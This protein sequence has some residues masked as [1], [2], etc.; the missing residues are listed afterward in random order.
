MLGKALEKPWE[1]QV[2]AWKL[3]SNFPRLGKTLGNALGNYAAP[4]YPRSF[5]QAWEKGSFSHMLPWCY[6]W[7]YH[8]IRCRPYYHEYTGSLSNS[9][10]KRGKA[11]LVLGSGTAWEPL[12]VLTAFFPAYF[13]HTLGKT[14]WSPCMHAVAKVPNCKGYNSVALFGGAIC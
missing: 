10:V 7:L 3:Q 14:S 9:E 4:I 8:S 12:R 6:W 13:S 2:Q 5:S 11:R 1:N